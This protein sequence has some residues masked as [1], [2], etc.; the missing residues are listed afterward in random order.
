MD[1]KAIFLTILGMAV[2]TAGPRILPVWL[3]AERD[4]PPLVER[5]L[6][7]IP[8]AVLSALLLPSLLLPEGAFD[9]SSSN[10]YLWAAIPTLF[11]AL[12]TRSL[13]GSVICGMLLVALARLVLGL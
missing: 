3:L 7:Y 6:K 12:K 5:W 13:F 9:F 4:L 2:V 8:V 1:Q 10:L 11:V